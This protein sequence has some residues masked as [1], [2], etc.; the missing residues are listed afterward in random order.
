MAFQQFH[1]SFLVSY[2]HA[3][4]LILRAFVEFGILQNIPTYF[5]L[6][7]LSVFLR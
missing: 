3:R 6:V 4:I 1:I 7:Y 5:P 2:E